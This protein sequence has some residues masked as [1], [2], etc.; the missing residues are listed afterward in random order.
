MLQSCESIL[1]EPAVNV[2]DYSTFEQWFASIVKFTEVGLYGCLICDYSIRYHY[3]I[4]RHFLARYLK[5]RCCIDCNLPCEEAVTEF[6][7]QKCNFP[8]ELII[9]R[10]F[11][12]RHRSL[13][14]LKMIICLMY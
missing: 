12:R 7:A 8:F 14:S 13:L 9:R 3:F 5:V 6:V 1:N 11:L 10:S 2:T 4:G